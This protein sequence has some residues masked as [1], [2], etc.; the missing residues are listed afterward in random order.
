LRGIVRS[1]IIGAKR[2]WAPREDG[3]F[4]TATVLTAILL[5]GSTAARAD[6][7]EAREAAVKR[8]STCTAAAARKLAFARTTGP[9]QALV[10][11]SLRTCRREENAAAEHLPLGGLARLRST[12]MQ[13]AAERIRA[14][15]E[16]R[17]YTEPWPILCA[18]CGMEP[19]QDP[20]LKVWRPYRQ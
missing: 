19:V 17:N 18:S 16:A 12:A 7:R 20:A 6:D 11:Q 8:F 3:M 13:E 9:L 10:G 14:I 4:R 1:G 15:R 2:D 5:I